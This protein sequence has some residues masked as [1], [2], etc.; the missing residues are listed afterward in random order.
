MVSALMCLVTAVYFEARSEPLDGQYAVAEVIMN[1]VESPRFPDTVCGVIKQDLGPKDHDCQFS[2]YC[3]GKPEVFKNPEALETAL[4]VATDVL[5]SER[6]A[7]IDTG[8]A[9]FYHTDYVNPSWSR[10]MVETLRAGSHI[11]LTD[12]VIPD[13]MPIV[14]VS[15]SS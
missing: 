2:F 15:E 5:S 12:D 6:G 11:F 1:R 4:T 9:L 3:D 13:D 10:Q 14:K 7:V 8:G